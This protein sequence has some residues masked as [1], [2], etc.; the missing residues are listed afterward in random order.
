MPAVPLSSAVML[1]KHPTGTY[2]LP[3]VALRTGHGV[4]HVGPVQP[5]AHAQEPS[6]AKPSKHV[7]CDPHAQTPAHVDPKRP[8][9]HESHA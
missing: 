1:A 4:E 7:P 2:T 5:A 8:D 9:A 6:P 3:D